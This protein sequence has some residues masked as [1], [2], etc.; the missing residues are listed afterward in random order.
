MEYLKI[1]GV[2]VQASPITL[3]C[4]SI[5]FKKGYDMNDFLDEVY[6][7]G[8]RSFDTARG[9]GQSEETLGKWIEAK[10]NRDKIVIITKCCLPLG[11]I[12]R[13]KVKNI[14]KDLE[15]SL[16]TLKTPYV[17]L[18]YL[19]RDSHKVDAREL[20]IEMNELIKEGKVKA[21]GVSNWNCE[22]IKLANDY[23]KEYGLSPFVVSSPQYSLAN[24]ERDPW[25]GSDGC[26][27]IQDNKKELDFYRNK[28]VALFPY[29]SLA[30]GFFAGKVPST[31][32]NFA[33]TLDRAAR[34]AY[35]SERNMGRLAR[36]EKM[37]EEKGVTPAA[38]NLAYMFSQGFAL[39]CVIA[40]SNPKRMESNLKASGLRLSKEEIAY[41]EG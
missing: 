31:S 11:Y 12:D 30:R 4:D 41:L 22:R 13:V 1:K 20:I 8:V 27:S 34:V 39:S 3:G 17:D 38:I 5:G 25:K 36:A 23:A 18:L 10:H 37:A 28:E 26:V 29:S 6:S 21:I 24:F 2:D 33:S 16:L 32:E 35:I 7:Y 40:T 14:R 9:Y 19:H 15:K